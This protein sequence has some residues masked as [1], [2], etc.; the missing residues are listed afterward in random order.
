VLAPIAGSRTPFDVSLGR[1]RRGRLVALYTRC[2]TAKG[3]RC[4]VYRYD[5]GSGAEQKLNSDSG[6]AEDEAWPVQEGDLLA[7]ARR[8]PF[9]LSKNA[10]IRDCDLIFVKRLS[11][12]APS[13]RLDRGACSRTTGISI[14]GTRIVQVTFGSPPGTRFA[15]QVRLLSA[16]GGAVKVLARQSSGEES[17]L[18]ASPSQSASS[19]WLTRTGVHPTHAFVRIDIASRRLTEVPA[20]IGLSGSLARDALSGAIYYVETPERFAQDCSEAASAPCRLTRATPSPFSTRE[21]TLAPVMSITSSANAGKAIFG[22][23][24]VVSG[25]LTRTVVSRG[26]VLRAAPVAGAVVRLLRRVEDP[27]A[28]GSLKEGF[29]PT[30][31]LAVTDAEHGTAIRALQH[32]GVDPTLLRDH[33]LRLLARGR[34]AER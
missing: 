18:F 5:V 26:R 4:D 1:N 33:T 30:L 27:A 32:L 8:R 19:I 28:V 34:S 9:G 11:S 20:R 7:F 12:R 29:Q 22:D 3:K 16:R 25:R 13:K 15:S 6:P 14:R 17:N 10:E 24:F 31:L 23:P 2:Q 21:R